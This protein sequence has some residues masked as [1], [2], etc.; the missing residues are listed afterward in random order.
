MG[1][2]IIGSISSQWNWL[3]WENVNQCSAVI[4][5]N[6]SKA[7]GLIKHSMDLRHAVNIVNHG[8]T[9]VTACDQPLYKIAKNIQ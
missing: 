7:V 6:D 8:Q 1:P 4:L 2:G 5:P 3:Y 9:P